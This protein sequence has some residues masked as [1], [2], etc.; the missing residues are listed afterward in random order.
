[1]TFPPDR[2]ASVFDNVREPTDQEWELWSQRASTRLWEAVA[3]S[4]SIEPS[5]LPKSGWWSAAKD[6]TAAFVFRHR[7]EAATSHV[8]SGRLTCRGSSGAFDS[9]VVEAEDFAAWAQAVGIPLPER[10]S[11]CFSALEPAVNAAPGRW[12]WGGHE[13]ELLRWLVAAAEKFWANYDPEDPSTAENSEAVVAW[14]RKQRMANGRQ[15]AKRV[16]EVMAQMLRAD[17]L[18]TGPRKK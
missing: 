7:F 16:A 12:P 5:S 17:G 10:L 9:W 11:G 3:L 6:G 15:I 2:P 18:P 8:T 1:M 14:L 13:T 4:C